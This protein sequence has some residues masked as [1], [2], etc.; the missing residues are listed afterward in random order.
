MELSQR[1]IFFFNFLLP[2]RLEN[3]SVPGGHIRLSRTL[4]PFHK[5]GFISPKIYYIYLFK[6][7][8]Y[9]LKTRDK[10]AILA[11]HYEFFRKHFPYHILKSIFSNGLKCWF[12]VRGQ[13]HF[14]MRLI[15]TTPYENEGSLCM[16][17]NMNGVTL[18][19]IAFTFASGKN[20]ALLDNQIIYITRIQG[21]KGSLDE[22]SKSSKILNDVAPPVLIVS[23]IEGLALALG[24]KTIMGISLE[25]QISYL[26]SDQYSFQKNYNE[27]WKIYESVKIYNGDYILPLPLQHKDIGLIRS[28]HRN[29][30][31]NKRKMRQDTSRKTYNFFVN[32]VFSAKRV[33]LSPLRIVSGIKATA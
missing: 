24:I 32:E 25:N 6:Y 27:F 7:L 3:I 2:Q 13:D 9:S 21:V 16:Q 1:I 28:K 18:Y 29:R 19:R 11:N 20:F 30:T 10:L 14:E 26:V 31:V 22:I 8:S 5:S 23:A 12:E 17:F 15:S 33:H 4:K